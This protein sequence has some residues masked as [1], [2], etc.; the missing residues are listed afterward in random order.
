MAVWEW[1]GS[2]AYIESISLSK[3]GW[4]CYDSHAISHMPW[5]DVIMSVMC[6][7]IWNSRVNSTA[8]SHWKHTLLSGGFGIWRSWWDAKI[9]RRVMAFLWTSWFFK[10]SVVKPITIDQ[11]LVFR[12]KS[13]KAK[14]R[15]YA[16]DGAMQDSTAGIGVGLNVDHVSIW[17]NHFL[18]QLIDWSFSPLGLSLALCTYK[19]SWMAV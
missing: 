12:K 2:H 3:I 8:Y 14:V 1:Y 17:W 4:S 11:S 16:A 10:S 13:G 7:Y 18:Y 15:W 6:M 9:C 5:L 19:K